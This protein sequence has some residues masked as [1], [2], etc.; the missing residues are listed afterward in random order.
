MRRRKL[1]KSHRNMYAYTFVLSFP[2]GLRIWAKKYFV[3][4]KYLLTLKMNYKIEK[5]M[6]GINISFH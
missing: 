1:K 3:G 2:A 4:S 5:S 6:K